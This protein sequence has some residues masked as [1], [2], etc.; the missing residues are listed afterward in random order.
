MTQHLNFAQN[1]P[2]SRNKTH[3]TCKIEQ[4]HVLFAFLIFF[5]F[6]VDLFILRIYFIKF[7]GFSRIIY[8]TNFTAF[9]LNNTYFCFYL[10][11]SLF[12]LSGAAATN[13]ELIGKF[14]V[15]S[16]SQLNSSIFHRIC[17]SQFCLLPTDRLIYSRFALVCLYLFK[18]M[19]RCFR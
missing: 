13:F 19:A 2:N 6:S 9:H 1:P 12:L 14:A 11:Y 18:I 10:F 16:K 8:T 4:K 17:S 3:T 5:S 7:T 15:S